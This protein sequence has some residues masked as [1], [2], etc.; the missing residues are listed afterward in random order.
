MTRFYADP[1]FPRRAL[2]RPLR[3]VDRAQ[4]R[5]LGRRRARR[6]GRRARR[7]AT[8]RATSTT[9]ERGVD[10]ADRRRREVAR[11]RGLG[12]ALVDAAPSPGAR[13]AAPT[14]CR[15]SRRAGTPPRSRRT[16]APG[17]SVES[18]RPLVPQ[19][20]STDDRA[21]GSPS[22]GRA[23]AG[24]ELELRAPARSRA[25]TS[26]ATGRSRAAARSCSRRRS[27]CARVLL[28]TS[29]THA[30]ELAALLLERRARRRGHRP[31]VHVRLDGER[32]SR[33][34]ARSPSSPTSGPTRS[35]ST[36]ARST[37][38]VS[39]AHEGDRRRRTTRAS[40]ARWTRSSRPPGA[41]AR[42]SSRTTR[43]AS[44]ATL[45]RATARHAS[46]RSRR[47]AST[48]RRTSRAARAARSSSTTRARR[49]APRSCARRARTASSSSA[50]RST[51]TRGST[52]GSSYVQ[53]DLLAAFL[54]AQLEA[55]ERIQAAARA[56]LA[57]LRATRSR[58]GPREH[59]V[60]LPVVPGAL[61][62]GVPHVLRAAARRS[63]RATRLIAHLASAGSSRSSTTCRCTSPPMG[64]RFGGR[65][66]AVPRDR[67]RQR[68]ARCA[69]RSSPAL[70]DAEQDEVIEA[71]LAFDACERRL[72]RRALR[73][74]RRRRAEE[75]LVP[76]AQ[77]ADR[78]D[79]P[80]ALPGRALACSR[81]AAARASCSRRC[82][83][84][85]PEL[86]L[87]GARAVRGGA[88]ARA[89][90]GSP[91]VELR[92]SSTR[93]R[94]RTTTSSTSSARSTCSST[95][96]RTRRCSRRCSRAARPGGG[97]AP[98][99]AAAPAALE[100]AWTD[101]ARPRAPL[102]ARA[103]SSAKVER[104]G[105]E[106]ERRRPRSCS[107]LLPAMVALARASPAASREPYDP[108]A[109]LEPGRAERA[110]SSGCSTASGG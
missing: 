99:R 108:V 53:S 6:R 102:H 52:L 65:E 24:H 73:A 20:V 70:T 43:T 44:S 62:A 71:V 101:V 84:R 78:L 48:R 26:P 37:S 47:R 36:S 28:T 66:G 104:A 58:T 3:H 69:C 81:S 38:L 56:D 45:P 11:G 96:R 32:R 25:A 100:R 34:A 5:G 105:F 57:P 16:S 50:A 14:R 31:V 4:P 30:L 23:F 18:H 63:R 77:P 90:R 54:L 19:V 89:A 103:S 109:E 86:R 94:C 75:L 29:C 13:T 12:V 67:G 85:F 106:V 76:R 35:T 107:S 91:D 1:R 42:R 60:Q 64:R 59:G 8:S 40:A 2:R 15:S 9:A 33:C 110:S 98:A 46:A 82:A 68:P 87:V 22:T 21:A 93:G 61:R 74:A 49:A 97:V 83:R 95:S 17:S 72:R 55:R 7:P 88:R 51:S 27:A 39:A 92:R 80:A 10:R 79:A 41:S